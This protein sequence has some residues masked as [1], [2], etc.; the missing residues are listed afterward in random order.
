MAPRSEQE[1][2]L[3]AV[4]IA[5]SFNERFKPLTANRP[6]CLLPL[7]NVPLIEYTLEFLAT[8]GVEEVFVVCC[9]HSEAIKDYIKKSRWQNSILPRVK[10]VVSQELLS[11]GDALREIDS[12]QLLQSD[13]VLVSGDVVSNVDLSSTIQEHR[14]RRK[15]TDKDAIMTMVLRQASVNHR[16]RA[17]GEESVFMLDGSTNECIHW[18]SMTPFPPKGFASLDTERIGNRKEIAVFNDLIDCQ[19]DICSVDVPA[20]FTENFDWQELRR[21]FL[22]GVLESELLGK[23]IYCH[24][25]KSHYAARVATPHM[26]DAVSKDVLAR[27]SYPMV[28]ESNMLVDHTYKYSRPHIYKENGVKLAITADLEENVAIGK[29]TIVGD[30]SRIL[31]SVI[32]RNC[33]IGARVVIQDAYI[34]DG[35]II[36]D[37]C[38]I[39]KCIID[40]NVHIKAKVKVESGSLIAQKVVIGPDITIA[41]NSKIYGD[42]DGRP[43]QIEESEDSDDEEVDARNVALGFIGEEWTFDSDV[44][45]D[46]NSES[47]ESDASDAGETEDENDWKRE[48]E[49]TL[50]RAFNEGHSIDIAA[51]ELNTLKMAMNISF[52]DLRKISI[53]SILKLIDLSKIPQS[54]DQVLKRWGKLLL[55]F[56]HNEEDQIDCLRILE[57]FCVIHENYVKFVSRILHGLY[58]L[59]VL[60]E[61]AIIKWHQSLKSAPEP[62]S[63]IREAAQ[64]LVQWL[65]EAEEED[66][67]EDDEDED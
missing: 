35:T 20:L 24:L 17:R 64:A 36:E 66:D 52:H 42:E 4:V 34:W 7:L 53:P 62:K 55:K 22:K 41:R 26:Y 2:V 32:G 45:C 56:S 19:I 27:W 39:S 43:L 47:D 31:N 40:C 58:D 46:V 9:A 59:D 37:D 11:V 51:L 28:P 65:Q 29:D 38:I 12:K 15:E 25:L 10:I 44:E 49:A 8:S 18:E 33:R 6:R 50:E 30:N 16:S 54:L 48:A 1:E 13:F 61:D 63:K 5:D 14:R 60:S 67:D 21:D 57:D 3:Q 23:T